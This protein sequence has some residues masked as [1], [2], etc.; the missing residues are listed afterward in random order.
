MVIDWMAMGY[1]F[2][3]TPRSYYESNKENIKLSDEHVQFMYQIFEK[4]E[5]HQ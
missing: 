4:L 1:V 2:G 5:E 3:D